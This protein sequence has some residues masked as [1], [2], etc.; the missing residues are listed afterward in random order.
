MF[1]RSVMITV[2]RFPIT[3]TITIATGKN[4]NGKNCDCRDNFF[5]R[6][7]S[8]NNLLFIFII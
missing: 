2:C 1:R 4:G 5:H 7:I 6:I 8:F 3:G